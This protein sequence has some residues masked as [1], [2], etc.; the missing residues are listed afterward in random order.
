MIAITLPYT[1][2]LATS[3]FSEYIQ[4]GQNQPQSSIN[5]KVQQ[6]LTDTINN[7]DNTS[8]P[9]DNVVTNNNNIINNDS[10]LFTI[11][12]GPSSETVHS[13]VINLQNDSLNKTFVWVL[14]G[15]YDINNLSSQSTTFNASFN[16]VKTEG[17]S[18]HSHNIYDSPVNVLLL[19]DASGNSTLLIRITTVSMREGQ[20][21]NV[22]TN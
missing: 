7:I 6:S 18:S 1:N 2:I 5:N 21:V 14:G 19:S 8:N 11:I 16:I 12:K 3:S 13:E 22:P 9:E 20:V 4:K 15:I 10:N 17:N